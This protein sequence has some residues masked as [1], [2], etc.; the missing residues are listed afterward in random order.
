MKSYTFLFFISF[1]LPPFL[2]A[3]SKLSK[4]IE[5]FVKDPALSSASVGVSVI[6]VESG[7]EI[8]AYN[9]RKSLTPA[10]AM[11]VL[12]TGAALK[13]LGADFRFQTKLEYDGYIDA[14]GNLIGNLYITGMGDPTLGSP[15]FKG[16]PTWA[17]LLKLFCD[18]VKKAGILNIAGQVVGDAAYFAT[19][20]VGH[21]WAYEDLGNYYGAG[22]YGLN[23]L[24]NKYYLHL[25]QNSR[26][27]ANPKIIKTTPKIP[28]LLLI[29]EL[30]SA[31]KGSGDNAYIFGAPQTYT[32]YVRGTI[33]VGKKIFTIK[34][35]IPDP[36]LYAAQSL[37]EALEEQGIN[38]HCE[39]AAKWQTNKQ[40]PNKR[41]TLYS[42]QS[43][44]LKSIVQRCNM[45]SVN[46]YCEAMLRMMGKKKKSDGTPEAGLE[47]LIDFWKAKG[48]PIQ[49]LFLEDGS[50]LSPYNALTAQHL[51]L[52]MRLIF[53]E[54]DW[55]NDF[56][57]SLP[58]AASSG[59]LKHRFK[60]SKAQ[61]NLRAKSGGLNRVRSFTGWVKNAQGK[62]VTFAIMV[63]N[64]IGEASYIL[65]KMETL[66]IS[67][68]E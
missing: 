36:P 25:Q 5:T 21:T 51:A 44:A 47:V 66:M 11:K 16:L 32:C 62:Q 23:V 24:E 34:G 13:I 56:E 9:S 31:P 14:H 64:Y 10:S 17:A 1:L 7:K 37:M 39:A 26:E 43:P 63:N 38:T 52:A 28:G 15:D 55:R 67:F 22:A 35:A 3:Q 41:H 60:G 54:E 45:K 4:A 30:H 6:S 50:G 68:S 12:T 20:G 61:N 18:K 53:K 29:N 42:Y 27:G 40:I 46:L 65:R 49:G 19:Q 33:P 58:L 2:F 48:L 59:A 57:A 8:A